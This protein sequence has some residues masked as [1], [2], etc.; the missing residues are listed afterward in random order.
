M[1][2]FQP[3]QKSIETKNGK[4]FYFSNR[5]FPGRPTAVFLHG[6]SS[7]HT[8]WLQIMETLRGHRYNSL[9]LDLR[10]HGLS[11]KTKK[12]GLYRLSVFSDDLEIIRKKENLGDFTLVGY[13]F[14]GEV[15]LDYAIRYPKSVSS[16]ILL[17]VNQVNVLKYKGLNFFTPILYVL[18]NLLAFLLL[19]QK[20]KNYKYYEHQK[21]A[22]YW[23]STLDGFLTMPISINL[24]MLSELGKLNFGKDLHA[25]KVPVVLMRAKDDPFVSEAETADMAAAISKS[26]IVVSKNESHFVATDSQNEVAEIILNFLKNHENSDL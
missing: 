7:N 19:W 6:L 21:A 10:G 25:I 26:K 8:T 23:G 2:N 15:A 1:N 14:G 13:S 3:E 20:R 12:R 24:W 18:F 17:S 22:G 16:L 4:I 11:D 9:A 5:P